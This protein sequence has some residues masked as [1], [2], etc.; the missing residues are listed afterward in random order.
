[1]KDD[2]QT[3]NPASEW[4]IVNISVSNLHKS[5]CP[6]T[7]MTGQA[8]L[9]MPVKI[10]GDGV[11]PEV[12][13]PDGTRGRM[14]G[15]VVI[16]L[17][18]RELSAWNKSQQVIV[19]TPVSHVYNAPGRSAEIV[20]EVVGGNRLM[21]LGTKGSYFRVEFPDGRQGYLPRS[22]SEE[23]DVW[24]NR[25]KNTPEGLVETA[26]SML[27][28]PYLWGGMSAKGVDAPGFISTVFRAHD[29]LIPRRL[30]NMARVGMRMPIEPERWN[31]H[32][33]DLLV[34]GKRGTA[35]ESEELLHVG[36]YI[37][38][39]HLIHADSRVRISGIAPGDPTGEPRLAARLL[40]AQRLLPYVNRE[41]SIMTTE[42]SPYYQ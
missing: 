41:P 11:W 39:Q 36:L 18:R 21:Y 29:I 40:R 38:N 42:Q 28:V 2:Y 27:G 4:G 8:L 7:E 23:L 24:R 10:L 26:R 20:S 25:L 14:D 15:H 16:R 17:T 1:M 32:P 13:T 37:G 33:A 19:T 6:M 30:H 5:D 3:K 34:F 9:G 22:H 12:L 31:L 35:E